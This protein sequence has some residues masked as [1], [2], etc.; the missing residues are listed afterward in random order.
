MRSI[1]LIYN[2]HYGF[3]PREGFSFTK[4]F[5]KGKKIHDK[6]VE[7]GLVAENSFVDP[8]MITLEEL[9]EVHTPGYVQS[10]NEDP[11]KFFT[12]SG[13]EF[14]ISPGVEELLKVFD[15]KPY[16]FSIIS[17]TRTAALLAWK[18]KAVAINLGGGFHHAGVVAGRDMYGG[19]CVLADTVV[20]VRQLRKTYPE[21]KNIL[22]IDC[23]Q[24]CGDGNTFSFEDDNT[25]FTFSIHQN[26]YF[27]P[28]PKKSNL[29]IVTGR[30]PGDR[31]YLSLLQSGLKE[32]NSRFSPDAVFFI[33][34]VDPYV[35]DLGGG[36]GISREGLLLRDRMVY[37]SVASR[38]L[39]LAIMLGGGYGLETWEIHYQFIADLLREGKN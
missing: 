10:L 2:E 33:E 34:G 19:Y 30:N 5:N 13:L 7:E 20:A 29:D 32:V 23:D 18:E 35:N 27:R 15:P 21:V 24:H 14:L 17:G 25:V 26:Q 1:F 3:Q 22:I 37:E 4:D 6:L 38:N 28:R 9:S 16:Y 39:P 8:G 31:R 11:S 12:L 36:M